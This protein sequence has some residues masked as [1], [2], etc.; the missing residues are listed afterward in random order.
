MKSDAFSFIEHCLD[1]AG[2]EA[3]FISSKARFTWLACGAL[4]IT[5][6]RS[7]TDLDSAII[8]VGVHGDEMI[9]VRLVDRWLHGMVAKEHA[10]RRPLLILLANPDA[11]RAERRFVESNMNRLFSA[12]SK[13]QSVGAGSG[14]R[15]RAA[16]LMELVEQFVAAHPDGVHLD[17]H[18]TIKPSDHDRFAIIP[19]QC[20]GRDMAPLFG[21]LHHFATDAWVQNI[22]PAATFTSFSASLGYTGATIELG[23]VSSLDEPIDRFLPLL[24]EMEHLA[25]GPAAP[26]EQV[27]IG[28]EVIDEIVRPEGAFEVCLDSFVNFRR[29]SKGMLIARTDSEEWRV[30]QEG[31]ALLFLNPSVPVGHRVALLVRPVDQMSPGHAPDR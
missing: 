27:G 13:E 29:L 23:Q 30:E 2:A 9:P 15:R 8:S 24:P 5:P 21:W 18:S 6:H 22:S 10:V 4:Q 1:P 25:H 14:E 12:S 28:Y 11:V 17:L 20:R 31:D 26:V 16:E 7:D 3:E 19:V